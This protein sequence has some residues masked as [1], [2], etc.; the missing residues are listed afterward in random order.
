VYE[1]SFWLLT[2]ILLY[3]QAKE[4]PSLTKGTLLP[5]QQIWLLILGLLS[6]DDFVCKTP[7]LMLYPV[8]KVIDITAVQN[9]KKIN[10]KPMEQSPY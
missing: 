4:Q 5:L 9:N 7:L 3:Y 6:I 10:T 2:F 8:D 1:F